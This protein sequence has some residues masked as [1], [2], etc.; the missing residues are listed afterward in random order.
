MTA[1]V[2]VSELLDQ[3]DRGDR[4]ALARV[5]SLVEQG[6]SLPAREAKSDDVRVIGITGSAGAGKSTLLGAL[7][8]HLRQQKIRVAALAC[9]PQSPKTGGALLGDRIRVRFDADDDG[10]YFR[11]LSTRGSPGG[12][13]ACTGSAI[14]WLKAFGFDVIL[15]ETVGAGQD[16]IAVR[17]VVDT[18][19]LMVTPGAGDEIQWEKAGVIELADLVIVNKS[20]MPGADL[21]RQQ[22]LHALS[23]GPESS[24]VPVLPVCALKGEG[25]ADLW[26]ALQTASEV[27]R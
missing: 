25:V 8:A 14:A 5:L 17:E 2:D 24:L 11:S 6:Q 15:V 4:Q 16:Q 9:D 21:V 7:I 23:L 19:A 1:S 10:V 22:V 13:A 12:I 27:R 26:T 20:D 18:L 3:F